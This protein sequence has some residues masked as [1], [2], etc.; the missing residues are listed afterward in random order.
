MTSAYHP[1]SQI[2]FEGAHQTL[3]TMLK[4]CTVQFSVIFAVRYE[5]TGFTPFVLAFWPLSER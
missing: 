3:T 2:A 5:S 4:T 1:Q